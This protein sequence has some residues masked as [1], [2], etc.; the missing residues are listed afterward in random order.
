MKGNPDATACHQCWEKSPPSWEESLITEPVSTESSRLTGEECNV[1]VLLLWAP[2]PCLLGCFPPLPPFPIGKQV[3]SGVQTCSLRQAPPRC[4]PALPSRWIGRCRVH[5]DWGP[6]EDA[7]CK[8]VS[9]SPQVIR[10]VGRYLEEEASER[11]P[12]LTPVCPCPLCPGAA[13]EGLPHPI[14]ARRRRK[15]SSV[16]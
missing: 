6:G 11:A 9:P 1:N 7:A 4:R 2:Q 10:A 5:F 14:M 3:G 8:A 13:A 15:P 12:G 16:K